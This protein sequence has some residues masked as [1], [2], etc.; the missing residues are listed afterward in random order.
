MTRG[1]YTLMDFP[2]GTSIEIHCTK[3]GRQGRYRRESL[4]HRYSPTLHLPDVLVALSA[5]CPRRGTGQFSDPC[6]AVY[7]T[8]PLTA[9]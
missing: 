7:G 5:D 2:S 3:C 9:R 4:L 6:E 8:Q 1:A